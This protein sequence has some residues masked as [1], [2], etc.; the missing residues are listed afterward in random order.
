MIVNLASAPKK[1]VGM[2]AAGKSTASTTT[3]PVSSRTPSFKPAGKS[4]S[5]PSRASKPINKSYDLAPINAPKKKSSTGFGI[6][7][8]PTRKNK[9]KD[10]VY[11]A[12]NYDHYKERSPTMYN[13]MAGD[14]SNNYEQFKKKEDM[15]LL[16]GDKA[17]IPDITIATA[18]TTISFADAATDTELFDNDEKQQSTRYNKDENKEGAGDVND[19]KDSDYLEGKND[20]SDFQKK[21]SISKLDDKLG[22]KVDSV[23]LRPPPAHK[24]RS[25]EST[26]E[27]ESCAMS[28]LYCVLMSCDCVLM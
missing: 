13:F 24:T 22:D 1:P 17:K 9:K 25:Q 23:Y 27:E 26:V 3:K 8:I 10:V 11:N 7:W 18:S 28:C 4:P 12:H 15:D 6:I 21:Q 16:P 19:K 2:L 20:S 5:L 14:S